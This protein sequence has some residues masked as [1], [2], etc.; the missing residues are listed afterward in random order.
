MSLD[1]S[2][3]LLDEAFASHLLA[4]LDKVI[5]NASK[6]DFIGPIHL[7]T[8][9]LGNEAPEVSIIDIGDVSPAF[10]DRDEGG[11]SAS[12]KAQ[13][14]QQ[15]HQQNQRRGETGVQRGASKESRRAGWTV[16]PLCKVCREKFTFWCTW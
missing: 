16:R 14:Q 10:L 13:Q 1:L 15:Q 8:L 3:S 11:G 6:P 9:E 7:S 12:L 2:W 4:T 5:S